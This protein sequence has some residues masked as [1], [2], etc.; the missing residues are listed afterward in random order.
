MNRGADPLPVA[1][2][3]QRAEALFGGGQWPAAEQMCRLVLNAEKDHF[4]ALEMLGILTAQT[5]RTGEALHFLERAAAARPD[6]PEG[7]FNYANLLNQ[8]GR[9]EEARAGYERA[10][11]ASPGFAEAY[12]NRG[13]VL[14]QLGRLEEALGAYESAAAVKSDFADSHNSHAAAL[15]DLGR[16]QEALQSCRRALEIRPDYPEAHH[17]HGVILQDLGRLEEALASHERALRLK[18]NF[19]EAHEGACRALRELRRFDE[20]LQSCESLLRIHP[21]LPEAHNNRG[22]IL[23]DSKRYA[24][25]LASYAKALEANPRFADAHKN[26]AATLQE[27]KRQEEALDSFERALALNPDLP[28][29]FGTV[30]FT[31]LELAQ[32]AGMESQ[33]EALASRVAQGRS[34]AQPFATAVLFDSLPLQQR[35]AQ[36]WAAESSAP[37]S[38][39]PP[40]PRP[41][42]RK[43][44]RV[45]YYSADYHEHATAHLAAGL[46]ET[47]D[48]DKFEIVAFSFG[49]ETHDGMRKRLVSSFDRFLDVRA[50]SDREIAELSRELQIDIA[51]DL[52]GFTQDERKGIFLH[53]AAPLQINYL[54]Y[55][56]TMATPYMDY[57]VADPVLIPAASRQYYTEKIVYLPNSYQVNDRKRE[58]SGRQYSRTELGL[59]AEGLVFCCFNNCFKIAPAV[60]DSW[61]R[62]LRQAEGS[63]LWLLADSEAATTN[64]RRNA[65]A[66]GVQGT[67]LI[68]A[69]REPLPEHLARHRAADLFLDTLPYNA[70]TTAS[71][72]LW[73][74]LPV[75]TRI[76]ESFAARVAASLLNAIHLPELVVAT[77]EQYETL[78]VELATDPA[79]LAQIRGRLAENRLTTPLFDTALFT[80]HLEDAYGQIHE[81]YQQGLPPDHILVG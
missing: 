79:R 14:R 73:A 71:D 16:L 70:H 66:R 36:C 57:L 52:K 40:F 17:T 30:M 33:M 28:W 21:D 78:A 50:K 11:A 55:P 37:R 59:P 34:A 43:R 24:E 62:I 15:R 47:H 26:R 1:Q 25:A 12:Y 49:P 10:I 35:A 6:K 68:F 41:A 42:R 48:R 58:I 77:A 76:G 60:F 38:A 5:G 2:A 61:M 8:L 29:L 80:R 75:L 9:F 67:R 18:P 27:L 69:R 20:A 74:G 56:G 7:H 65:E 53:R 39:L 44:I 13:N 51:V 64:L 3:M 4:D 63:V 81:R 23:Q 46:F 54:G 19:T 31:R 72:A 32:W 22:V 45:G